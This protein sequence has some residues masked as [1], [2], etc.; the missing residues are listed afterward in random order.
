[1]AMDLVNLKSL[2]DYY[3]VN[4]VEGV[5][6]EGD[7]NRHVPSYPHFL[8]PEVLKHEITQEVIDSKKYVI[9]PVASGL[10]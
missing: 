3:G 4:L 6:F 8:V 9:T 10:S 2:M 1:M 7:S 5:V